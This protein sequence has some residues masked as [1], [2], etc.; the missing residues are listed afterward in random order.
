MADVPY[1]QGSLRLRRRTRGASVWELRFRITDA[2]GRRRLKQ[3]IVGSVDQYPTE[4]EMRAKI[5]G[6]MLSINTRW[7]RVVKPTFGA[8]ADR[9]IA[10]EHLEEIKAGQDGGVGAIRYS[11]AAAYLNLIAKHLRPRWQETVLDAMRPAAVQEWLTR[12]PYSPKTKA[13]IKTLL[14]RLFE[15]AML[16]E[17]IDIQRNPMQ[18]V[19]VKGISKRRRIPAVLTPDQFHV[20]VEHLREPQ[21]TMVIVAQCTG[22]RVSEILGLQWPDFDFEKSTIQI[23]RGVVNGRVSRLK[24]EYSEDLLPLD[25]DLATILLRWRATSPPSPEGWVFANPVTLKPYHASSIQKRYFQRVGDEI[26]IPFG[27]HTFRHT[28]RSWLDFVGAPVGVQ[29]KLMRHAQISTTMNTYGNALMASKRDAND[30]VV[31]MALTAGESHTQG[32]GVEKSD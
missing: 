31:G 16:W 4:G 22:L 8:L 26:G 27:W 5:S 6:V 30:K 11:T 24:T 29:Q 28:Y 18:L 2:Q 19:E 17:A 1:Q 10:E 3:V 13:N 23:T 25:A 15:K 21:R 32:R 12:L 14:H 20:I 9:F 7:P